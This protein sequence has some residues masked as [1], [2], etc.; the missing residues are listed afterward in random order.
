MMSL[1]LDD[2]P[3]FGWLFVIMNFADLLGVIGSIAFNIDQINQNDWHF[4]EWI[5]SDVLLIF[6]LIISLYSDD[7]SDLFDL[8]IKICCWAIIFSI[9]DYVLNFSYYF[10]SSKKEEGET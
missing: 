10:P 7:P 1:S 2:P 5:F 6:F 4:I 3:S 9:F 8:P